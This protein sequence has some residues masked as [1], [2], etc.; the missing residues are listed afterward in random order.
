M[1]AS[2]PF[3]LSALVF[4]LASPLAE[5]WAQRADILPAPRRAVS[6]ETGRALLAA[7]EAAD[8]ELPTQLASPFL[9]PEA[10][11]TD[12]PVVFVPVTG[13]APVVARTYTDA[14]VL[15]AVA[16]R[17]TPTGAVV[18][19]GE[20]ILLFGQKRLKVGDT[21]SISFEGRDYDVVITAIER[22][23][24]TL[25]LNQQQVTRPL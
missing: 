4:L 8:L 7:R 11:T 9:P 6:L 3:H 2:R 20:S 25:R 24:F 1:N 5:A 12:V 22:T 18:V 16:P 21:Y 13:G 19:G 15:E 14:E 10:E 23:S 17:I